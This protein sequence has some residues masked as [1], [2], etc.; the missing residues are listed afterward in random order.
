L[1]LVNPRFLNRKKTLRVNCVTASSSPIEGD[2]P[3]L[4]EKAVGGLAAE[5][6]GSAVQFNKPTPPIA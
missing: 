3:V 1:S 2:G 5:R 4:V 6:T